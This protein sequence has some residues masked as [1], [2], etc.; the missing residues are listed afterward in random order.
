MV[1]TDWLEI[2]GLGFSNSLAAFAITLT[3]ATGYLVMAYIVG[4]KLTTSQL[5]ILNILF[6]CVM[7]MV[8]AAD[9]TALQNAIRAAHE[10]GKL[11]PAWETS[12]ELNMKTAYL[13][14]AVNL[15][16]IC[17]CLKFM[18]DIRNTKE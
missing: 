16:L 14:L 18:W 3:M 13:S 12:A 10:A 2:A 17:G 6:L 1:A 4:K 9:F 5:W 8:A 11:S 7:L 15:F